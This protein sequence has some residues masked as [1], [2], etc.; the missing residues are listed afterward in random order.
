[1]QTNE[2]V[3]DTFCNRCMFCRPVLVLGEPFPIFF[4]DKKESLQRGLWVLFLEGQSSRWVKENQK[5]IV[6]YV[7][8]VLVVLGILCLCSAIASSFQKLNF[9]PSTL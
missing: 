2:I 7:A 8:W 3:T 6:T 5:K 4:R 1:M 9:D